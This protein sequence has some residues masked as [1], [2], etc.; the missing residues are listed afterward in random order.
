MRDQQI[1]RSAGK[2]IAGKKAVAR[3][4]A[5]HRDEISRVMTP[6]AGRVSEKQ[7]IACVPRAYA[8]V[9]VDGH[10]GNRFAN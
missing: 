8:I 9:R 6:T 3:L 2:Q 5:S 4:R 1:V 7:S 10:D